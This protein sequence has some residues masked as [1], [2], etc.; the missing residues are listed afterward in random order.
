VPK[1]CADFKI[2]NKVRFP[3][4]V[5]GEV[6][7][8]NT[9]S[10]IGQDLSPS[11]LRAIDCDSIDPVVR[12]LEKRR[13]KKYP[14]IWIVSLG[15]PAIFSG[16][17]APNP[18]EGYLCVQTGND[19]ARRWVERF[20]RDHGWRSSDLAIRRVTLVEAFEIAR[21]LPK[22][23]KLVGGRGYCGRITGVGI[24]GVRT[25]RFYKL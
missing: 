12:G 6:M 24:E 5:H 4:W 23:V 1:R 11:L 21:G 22:P 13:P 8:K 16:P 14:L 3:R 17:A 25:H 18:G 10:K 19:L 20:V 15:R 2:R 7:H 9:R